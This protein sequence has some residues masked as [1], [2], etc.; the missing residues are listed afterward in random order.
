MRILTLILLFILLPGVV[1]AETTSVMDDIKFS[2]YVGFQK[3]WHL[4]TVRFRTDSGEQRFTYANDKAWKDLQDADKTSVPPI[5][6]KGAVFAKIGIL[7]KE[8]PEFVNSKVPAGAKRFQFMVYNAEKYKDT[9]GWGYAL[10]TP[11]GL[12]V[13]GKS[14]KEDI[15][16]CNA[17]H[18][19]VGKSRNYVFSQIAFLGSEL[20]QDTPRSKTPVSVAAGNLFSDYPFDKLPQQAKDY[21]PVHATVVRFLDGPMR[22][23]FFD[24]TFVEI[25]PALIEESLRSGKPA[26][27]LTKDEKQFLEVSDK[28]V[29]SPRPICLPKET[30]HQMTFTEFTETGTLVRHDETHC[31]EDKP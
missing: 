3:K 18:E 5:F 9:H 16:A 21:I 11:D 7:T 30:A 27:L 1:N 2:D 29:L 13:I 20:P 28:G 17:C 6:S 4:V 19:V 31:Y 23:H 22:E 25:K 8:D 12:H 15:M 24:G 14:V 26:I 10:F